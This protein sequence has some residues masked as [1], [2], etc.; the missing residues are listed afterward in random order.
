VSSFHQYFLSLF[1]FLIFSHSLTVQSSDMK[2][3]DDLKDLS[4]TTKQMILEAKIKSEAQEEARKEALKKSYSEGDDLTKKAM[5]KSL[6][7]LN[8]GGGDFDPE[9]ARAA[10]IGASLSGMN[11]MNMIKSMMNNKEQMASLGLNISSQLE[12]QMKEG[13]FKNF[14]KMFPKLGLFLRN[15]MS[16]P[17]ILK[18]VYTLSAQEKKMK[19]FRLVALALILVSFVLNLVLPA[20]PTLF[21][22]IKRKMFMIMLLLSGQAINLFLFL[23]VSSKKVAHI[24]WTTFISS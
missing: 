10:G 23:P 15:V 19:N 1:S 17:H 2:E 13:K 3:D 22:R 16:E 5:A 8:S 24:F 6:A 12:T 21:M 18:E 9:S 20:A 14:F 7:D 4:P 11:P